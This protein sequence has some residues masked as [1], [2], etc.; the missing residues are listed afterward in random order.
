MAHAERFDHQVNV[1][2]DLEQPDAARQWMVR[3]RALEEENAR[4]RLEQVSADHAFASL[5]AAGAV[6]STPFRHESKWRLDLGGVAVDVHIY[7]A[8]KMKKAAVLFHVTNQGLRDPWSLSEVQLSAV[9]GGGRSPEEP[10]RTGEKKAF[11]LRTSR[12]E[13]MPGESGW[14][15][16]VTDKRAFDSK[17]GPVSLVLELFRHDGLQQAVVYLDPQILTGERSR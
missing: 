4:L 9:V 11:A 5:L 16:V 15:A 13:I 1:F 10:V 14:I 6:K 8:K 3:A 2:H 7:S 12:E 17:E